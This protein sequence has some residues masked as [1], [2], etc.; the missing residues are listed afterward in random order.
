MAEND[1]NDLSRLEKELAAEPPQKAKL[2][3]KKKGAGRSASQP[4]ILWTVRLEQRWIWVRNHLREILGG[5]KS[6][7]RPTR[8][9]SA[10]FLLSFVA[11]IFVA[12]YGAVYFFNAGKNTAEKFEN[13][14]QAK[15]LSELFKKQAEEA[16]RRNTLQTLG[17]FT[18]ELKAVPGITRPV[19]VTNLAIV[20]M[21]VECDSRETC[22]YVEDNVDA[23]RNQV[24]NV[25]V[26]VDRDD[27][28]SREG[29]RK[30]KKQVTEKLNLWLPHGRIESLFFSKLVLS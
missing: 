24:T 1:L 17:T 21:V 20:E 30:I 16:K 18:V 14:E 4:E 11:L 23:A 6:T 27:L 15:S 22:V 2:K 9:M 28:L 3:K 5:L 29:K 13:N 7:D 12:G 26:A 10:L 19:G 8:R 25:F